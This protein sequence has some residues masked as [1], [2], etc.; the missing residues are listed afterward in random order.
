M[1]GPGEFEKVVELVMKE[2]KA[3]EAEVRI[4]YSDSSLT[5]F[6]NSRI[7]QNVAREMINVSIRAV[8]GKRVGAAGVGTLNSERVIECLRN[9]EKI[10]T[11]QPED[12]NFKG[13]PGKRPGKNEPER[14]DEYT[15]KHPPEEKAEMIADMIKYAGDNNVDRIYGALATTD[16]SVF[17][18]NSNHIRQSGKFSRADLSTTVI[19]DWDGDRGFGRAEVCSG[20]IRDIDH[21]AVIKTAVDKGLNNMDTVS[22]QPG[23]YTVILEP[24]AVNSLVLYLSMMGLSAKAVQEQ[25][26]FMNGKFGE[27]IMDER[28]NLVDDAFNEKTIGYG[29]D[30]EGMP[31]QRV[32]M[33]KNG[34]ANAVVYDSYTAGREEGKESTGHALPMPSSY[35]PMAMNLIMEGGDSSVKEMI[36]DTEKGILVTR[37]NYL[38]VVHPVKSIVTGLTRDG[39][40]QIEDGEVTGPV[41]NLRFTQNL[42]DAFDSV[43]LIGKKQ[44]LFAMGWLS[45]HVT[46]PALKINN[47]NFTGGTEF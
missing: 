1:V 23:E 10:A 27:R 35:S 7:H 18:A 36:E 17:M 37:F 12:P 2:K 14:Y 20:D 28:I 19:A 45:G 29:F 44:E 6:A 3:D 47:F 31:K 30:F 46:C 8:K 26:S 39:T 16:S 22:V 38:G 34:V 25:R 32:E 21:T 43:E 4:I 13:L 40:W 9:A 15:A 24:M 33:I 11:L 42:V 5:R 41:K